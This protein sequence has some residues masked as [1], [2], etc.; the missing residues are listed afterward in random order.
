MTELTREEQREEQAR[1][2]VEVREAFRIFD[3]PEGQLVLRHMEV[4]WFGT[5]PPGVR[6]GNGSL[7]PWSSIHNGGKQA[8]YFDV[9]Q[10]IRLYRQTPRGDVQTVATRAAPER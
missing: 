7:D 5:R 6:L 2:A 10:W 3:S 9:Q 4:M 1:M 8:A